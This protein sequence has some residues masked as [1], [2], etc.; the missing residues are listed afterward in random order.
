MGKLI[1]EKITSFF[2]GE[3]LLHLWNKSYEWFDLTLKTIFG[4]IPYLPIRD[5][6]INPWFWFI[7]AFIFILA[8]IFRRR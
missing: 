6:L 2:S 8:L 5:L 3:N 1:I 4:K 7:L